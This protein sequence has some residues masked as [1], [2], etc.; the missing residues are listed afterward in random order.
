MGSFDY[1]DPKH[2]LSPGCYIDSDAPEVIAF[3]WEKGG[4]GTPREKAIRLF[5]AVRDEFWYDPY[6]LTLQP[7]FF[8]ASVC[9]TKKT[10]VCI[11]KAVIYT[12]VLRAA[13]IP[14]RIAF[15]DVKNH[16]TTGKLMALM[17]SDVFCCHGYTQ[18]YLDEKWISATPTFNKEL[19]EKFGLK[20]L[21]FDGYSDCLLHPFDAAGHRHMEYVKKLGSFIDF[22]F[23][24]IHERLFRKYPNMYDSDGVCRGKGDFHQEALAIE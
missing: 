17:E 21:E 19:C 24:Y 10:G 4:E 12:A 3:A 2:Y 8:K 7:T 18:L 15:A 9:V 23:D 14:A 13:G 22:P 1:D 16:L 6:D 5:T 11:S 20:P